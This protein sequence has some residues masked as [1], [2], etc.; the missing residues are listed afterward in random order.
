MLTEKYGSFTENTL[1]EGHPILREQNILIKIQREKGNE[2]E[3]VKRKRGENNTSSQNPVG[4]STYVENK[5]SA[6]SQNVAQC[7][8]ST[9]HQRKQNENKK[10]KK[11]RKKEKKINK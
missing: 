3:E 8:E 2:E 1:F 7:V 4:A 10:R 5:T 6:L 9:K 11:K